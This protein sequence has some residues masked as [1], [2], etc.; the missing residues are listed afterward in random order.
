MWLE[1]ENVGGN[2]KLC[3]QKFENLAH[4]LLTS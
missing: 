4:N 2:E 3:A 1:I